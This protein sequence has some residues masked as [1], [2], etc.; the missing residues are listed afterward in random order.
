VLFDLGVYAIVDGYHREAVLSF[1]SAVER[2]YEFYVKIQCERAELP[3]AAID[4]AWKLIAAQS[5]RQLGGFI[6]AH[7]LGAKACTTLMPQRA[8]E[9]R[10]DTAH[11]G[12]IPSREEALKYGEAAAETIRA[13]AVITPSRGRRGNQESDCAAPG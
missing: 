11:K 8:V 9:L 12:R 5:E 13:P 3:L 10:N 1:A 7:L 4:A 6:I 2:F